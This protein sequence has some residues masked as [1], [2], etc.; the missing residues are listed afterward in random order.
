MREAG[1]R[2]QAMDMNQ[3]EERRMHLLP[4]SLE[5]CKPIV[6]VSLCEIEREKGMR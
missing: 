4:V 1:E 2:E 3:E 5:S 6:C